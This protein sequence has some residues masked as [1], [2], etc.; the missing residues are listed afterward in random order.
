VGILITLGRGVKNPQGQRYE[1]PDRSPAALIEALKSHDASGPGTGPNDAPWWSGHV[2]DGDRRAKDGWA[3]AGVLVIDIDG[4][5][6]ASAKPRA[7]RIDAPIEAH[8]QL[9]ERLAGPWA[10][11][12]SFAHT[13]PRGARL[14]WILAE[15][16][17]TQADAGLGLLLV[18]SL[19][20][21]IVRGIEAATVDPPLSGIYQVDY[22]ANLDLARLYYTPE[23]MGRKPVLGGVW[24]GREAPWTLEELKALADG[25]GIQIQK[26]KAAKKADAA[27]ARFYAVGPDAS[28]DDLRV[29]DALVLEPAEGP[30]DGSLELIHLARKAVGLGVKDPETFARLAAPWNAKRSIPWTPEDLAKRYVDVRS[31]WDSEGL[32]VGIMPGRY[33]RP[34]LERI[35]RE[36]REFTGQIRYN[37]LTSE[38]EWKD[39]PLSEVA[40]TEAE[41][42]ICQR[43]AFPTIPKEAVHSSFAFEASRREYDPI[44]EYLAGLEWD[45]VERLG[46]ASGALVDRLRVLDP[47]RALAASYLRCTL[48]AA[49]ARVAS[50]GCKHDHVPIL[51]GPDRAGKSSALRAL[52]GGPW[53]RDTHLEVESKDAYLQLSG[54]WIYEL[55]ELDAITRK[56]DVGRLKAFV[57]SQVDHFRPPFER[58]TVGRPRRSIFVGTSNTSEIL[59]DPTSSRRWWPVTVDRGIDLEWIKAHRDQLWAESVSRFAAGEVWWLTLEQEELRESANENYHFSGLAHSEIVAEAL[60]QLEKLGESLES[61]PSLRLTRACGFEP[62]KVNA[63]DLQKIGV[64]MRALGYVSMHKRN[65]KNHKVVFWEKKPGA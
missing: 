18:S 27:A 2:W 47:G 8:I 48:I 33:T 3:G 14:G 28:P 51:V 23:S 34:A 4:T 63:R 15:D 6:F 46:T 13:T 65:A 26:P 1:I 37:K 20:D 31:R 62:S 60:A 64:A 21:E 50:P 11:R 54:V 55:S 58:F 44:G 49:V 56:A 40:V 17:T 9:A 32:V 29:I 39:R 19:A 16:L 59:Q 30:G 35:F 22:K 7:K 42:L 5:W 61:V 24:P 43:Y 10:E 57:S 53:F 41:S 52:A 12:W 45:G 36:D 25:L 38:I